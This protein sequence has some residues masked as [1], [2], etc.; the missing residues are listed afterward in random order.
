MLRTF[1]KNKENLQV[2]C[3]GF[4]CEVEHGDWWGLVKHA[5]TYKSTAEVLVLSLVWIDVFV[6]FDAKYK[7]RSRSNMLT[8]AVVSGVDVQKEA[9]HRWFKIHVHS[10]NVRGLKKKKKK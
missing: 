9:E 1:H 5:E 2:A 7:Q 8:Q 6:Q 4:P 3:D 10:T